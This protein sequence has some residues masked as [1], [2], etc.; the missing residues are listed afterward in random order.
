MPPQPQRP[1]QAV[2]PFIDGDFS[3]QAP[4]PSEHPAL[5]L[6]HEGHETIPPHWHAGPEIVFVRSGTY[7]MVVD[8]IGRTVTP[9]TVQI[10]NSYAVHQGNTV[11]TGTE[12]LRSL[13][14]TFDQRRIEQSFPLADH[15]V[16]DWNASDASDDDRAL[17]LSLCDELDVLV[18]RVGA[19]K[20]FRMNLIMY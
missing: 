16:L 9:G 3:E 10:T 19:V 13:S 12:R 4:F 5:I 15:F 20:K 11:S 18:D 7:H 6:T 2:P 8:G 1:Y 14:L 17:L